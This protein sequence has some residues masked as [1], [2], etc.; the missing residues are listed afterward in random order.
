MKMTLWIISVV[1]FCAIVLASG[2]ASDRKKA[3]AAAAVKPEYIT[4]ED[5]LYY[6]HGNIKIVERTR[7]PL[8]FETGEYYI[9]IHYNDGSKRTI[10]FK[11]VVER[12]LNY[13]KIKGILW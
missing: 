2:F 8:D 1:T 10:Y 13:N 11:N 4:I 3:E 12:D 5:D 9:I 7:N 6:I